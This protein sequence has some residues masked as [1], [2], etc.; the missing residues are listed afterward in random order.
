MEGKKRRI[1]YKRIQDYIDKKKLLQMDW[2]N[3]MLLNNGSNNFSLYISLYKKAIINPVRYI[4]YSIFDYP[5]KPNE[6]P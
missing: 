4:S 2:L 5:H 3:Y 1:R 6:K